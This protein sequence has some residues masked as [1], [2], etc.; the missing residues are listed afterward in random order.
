METDPT[1][2]P[3]RGLT[4][5]ALLKGVQVVLALAVVAGFAGLLWFRSGFWYE[6]LG[7][8]LSLWTIVLGGWLVITADIQM[9]RERLHPSLK[10]SPRTFAQHALV[11]T[12]LGL[13]FIGQGLFLLLDQVWGLSLSLELSVLLLLGWMG[14]CFLAVY[15][16]NRW[17]THQAPPPRK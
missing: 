14:C 16:F 11:G 9:V 2:Q 15:A 8:F 6:H 12:A 10:R 4:G 5:I 1:Q 7:F 3:V 17:R 13:A